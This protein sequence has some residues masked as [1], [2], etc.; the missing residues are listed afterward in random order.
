MSSKKDKNK[1]VRLEF[2]GNNATSVTGSCIH[3]AMFDKDLNREIQGLLEIGMTQGD[4]ILNNYKI[5]D[6]LLGKFDAKNLDF[7]II[8]HFHADHALLLSGLIHRSFRGK[9]YL[10][11]ESAAVA[12]IMLADGLHIN[13]IETKWLK[14]K[15]GIK[16]KPFYTSADIATT[17]NL[18]E[19]VEPNSV[20]DITPNIQ[21]KFLESRHIIGSVT[22]QLF[23]KDYASHIHKLFYT[24]DLGNVSGGEK[25]FVYDTQEAPTTSTV[26]IYESTYGSKKKE[27]VNN[28]TRKKELEI[29]KNTLR[30]TLLE[31]KGS[32][33][34]PC[35]SLDR[36]PNLL[37]NLKMIMDEDEELRNIRV[38]VDGKLTNELLDVYWKT[39]SGQNKLDI[40]EIIEWKNLKRIREYKET[41]YY[42]DIK[43]PTIIISSAGFM[44]NGHVLLYAR[45]LLPSKKNTLIFTGYSP[46]N[47]LSY[48][49]K[50]KDETG[51]KTAKIDKFTVLLNAE[52]ISLD[53]F[54]SHIQYPDLVKY[55]L[56]TKSESIVLVHGEN[57]EDLKEELEQKLSEKGLSTKVILPKKNQILYF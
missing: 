43:E 44:S 49:L 42:L 34:L 25:Y 29:L 50:T 7:V 48:K 36:T 2:V 11:K 33:L 41:L 55:I 37:K 9:I 21:L 15:K 32:C 14:D 22:T 23:F 57:K 10:T 47:S 1:M 6:T 56:K 18:I 31:K 35:F 17:M 5:N 54:S 4:T 52:V 51:Q 16:A 46:Q 3:I 20:I 27:F 28:K 40:N 19:M 53:S 39:C 45:E 38:I 12:P 13:E 8:N 26:S 30:H 24:S